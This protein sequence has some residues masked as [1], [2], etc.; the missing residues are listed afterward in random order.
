MNDSCLRDPCS[1]WISRFLIAM[2]IGVFL[3]HDLQTSAQGVRV[4][5]VSASTTP[6]QVELRWHFETGDLFRWQTTTHE[7]VTDDQGK[8]YRNVRVYDYTWFVKSV[9]ALGGAIIEVTFDRIQHRSQ[10]PNFAFDTRE[11]DAAMGIAGDS[12]AIR[13]VYKLRATK[14]SQMTIAVTSRGAVASDLVGGEYVPGS[15]AYTPG[16]LPALPESVVRVGEQWSAKTETGAGESELRGRSAYRV[17]RTEH[18]DHLICHL[19]G[20]NRTLESSDVFAPLS[21]LEVTSVSRFNAGL[22]HFESESAM[23]Q[24][25]VEVDT[26]KTVSVRL[27]SERRLLQRVK[28]GKTPERSGLFLF[29]LDG[30][31][32]KPLVL[33]G[34]TVAQLSDLP[35]GPRKLLLLEFY[36][37]WRDKDQNGKP[38]PGE[39]SGIKTRFAADERVQFIADTK[40]LKNKELFF[41]VVSGD[42]KPLFRNDI[43]IK[44]N[45]WFATRKLPELEPGIYFIEFFLSDRYLIR[46]PVQVYAKHK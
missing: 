1:A 19:E 36:H 22:G 16:D 26:G 40:G 41:V 37:Q 29:G 31:S 27:N 45:D 4:H 33:N 46:V 28:R 7:T 38:G 30:K 2:V 13:L 17:T 12:A 9:D 24:F 10:W 20:V 8:Q 11:D 44:G 35:G 6:G 39:L 32:P 42:G 25:Q 18:A 14:A 23:S 5:P 21:T 43:A 3:I 15:F 34:V